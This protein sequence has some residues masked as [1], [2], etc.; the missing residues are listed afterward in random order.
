MARSKKVLW[1]FEEEQRALLVPA[2]MRT[3]ELQAVVERTQP[4][5]EIAGLWILRVTIEEL[6]STYTLV[7]ELTNATRSR[8]R[9]EILDGLRMSLCTSIDG[10]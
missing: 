2:V 3:P 1:G 4:H 5:G 7:E 6:N 9:I 8:R 10:S